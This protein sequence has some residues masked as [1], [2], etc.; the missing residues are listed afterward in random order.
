MIESAVTGKDVPM[1]AFILKPIFTG[2]TLSSGGSGGI[3]TPTFL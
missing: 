3:L 1:L 2:I